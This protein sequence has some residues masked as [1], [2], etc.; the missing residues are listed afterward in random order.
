MAMSTRSWLAQG[1]VRSLSDISMEDGNAGGPSTTFPSA[2]LDGGPKAGRLFTRRLEKMLREAP[3]YIQRGNGDSISIP[4]TTKFVEHA[5][6]GAEGSLWVRKKEPLPDDAAQQKAVQEQPLNSCTTAAVDMFSR[7]SG[8]L[9]LEAK[10]EKLQNGFDEVKTILLL[11]LGEMESKSKATSVLL[12]E[13]LNFVRPPYNGNGSLNTLVEQSIPQTDGA[14]GYGGTPT[15]SAFEP[16]AS[17]FVTED[18]QGAQFDLGIAAFHNTVDPAFP[19]GQSA[20]LETSAYS[21]EAIPGI[22]QAYL[23]GDTTPGGPLQQAGSGSPLDGLYA[24]ND[25]LVDGNNL[26]RSVFPDAFQNPELFAAQS[27][28][29]S[30]GNPF[31]PGINGPGTH[32]LQGGGLNTFQDPLTPQ[33]R[34]QATRPRTPHSAI[35]E[36]A[37]TFIQNSV[38]ASAVSRSRTS[39]VGQGPLGPQS[40]YPEPQFTI[41]PAP[42][43]RYTSQAASITS[44]LKHKASSS[45]RADNPSTRM[46]QRSPRDSS[47]SDFQSEK[48]LFNIGGRQPPQSSSSK[49]PA[50]VSPPEFKLAG[51]RKV[52]QTIQRSTASSFKIDSPKARSSGLPGTAGYVSPQAGAIKA[53]AVPQAAALDAE[54]RVGR[55][56]KPLPTIEPGKLS[57]PHA[58]FAD[59]L[60]APSLSIAT[61]K[62]RTCSSD[63]A[64]SK[65]HS[66][67]P[68]PDPQTR[69]P[70][71]SSRR[72]GVIDQ[73][74]GSEEE[75]SDTQSIARS[76]GSVP[77]AA[78]PL[79]RTTVRDLPSSSQSGAFDMKTKVGG[80]DHE[81]YDVL[82]F[83][84]RDT[85]MR[86]RGGGISHVGAVQRAEEEAYNGNDGS[87]ENGD[88]E[89]PIDDL[90]QISEQEG[91]DGEAETAW[92][93]NDFDSDDEEFSLDEEGG[94]D[95][96]GLFVG[97][98]D[99]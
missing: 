28:I 97:S 52:Q 59:V 92:L 19:I 35:P 38:A 8:Q 82:R 79:Q 26:L 54:I 95:E 24:P 67:T 16:R 55:Q 11:Y 66:H 34:Q 62:S 21:F 60:S 69:T 14:A 80:E 29:Q 71:L 45:S 51:T 64:W 72:Q 50:A 17:A 61:S 77:S 9:D 37:P 48:I 53:T 12:Q 76:E 49:R 30:F 86:H 1:E 88:F 25:T 31:P 91:S 40:D 78:I 47:G 7:P 36:Q 22:P 75:E 96:D 5:L 99:D 85:G 32:P 73:T 18:S 33:N 23:G 90:G 43:M 58:H 57:P 89:E 70:S 42:Q 63:K 84:D 3:E 81:L 93:V 94:S 68:R 83:P 13:I 87:N 74:Q 65:R 27:P 39:I 46:A 56:S 98:D 15:V 4:N 6:H 10:V 44:K 41:T 2:Q 20:H